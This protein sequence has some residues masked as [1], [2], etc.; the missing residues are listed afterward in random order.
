MKISRRQFAST[1]VG[2]AGLVGTSPVFS[3]N[4]GQAR[5]QSIEHQGMLIRDCTLKGETRADDVVPAHPSGLQVSRDRWLLLYA[6]RGFRGVD[7]D[8]SIVYQLRQGSPDG[9]VLCEGF[10]VRTRN[11]WDPSNKGERLVKQHGHPVAFGVSKGALIGGRVPA[12]AN[13]FVAKWRVVARIL[14]RDK[15]YLHH[16]TTDPK[17]SQRT[18]GVEWIQFRLNA[19]EDDI[20]IVQP[21]ALLRQRGYERG[22]AFCSREDAAHMN[23]SF[24]PPLPFNREATE[25]ADC[26][27][28]DGGRIAA[29][30]Y[31]YNAQ[32][33]LYEWVATGPFVED[34]K[35]TL[36]EASL[37]R[38]GE[39]W[40]IAARANGG[41][42]IAWTQTE[43][44]FR[45][46]PVP[47]YPKEPVSNSPVTA[48][49]CADGVLRLFTGSAPLSATRNGRDPLFCWDID[50]ASQF[51][52]S[53]RR[54]I[55]DSVKMGLHIRPEAVPKIDMCKLLPAQG[56][57]QYIIHR[58]SV[59]SYNHPYVGGS[60][61]PTGIPAIN[62]AEKAAC[63]IYYARIL[64]AEDMPSL[65]QFS[66][67]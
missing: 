25:W 45:K 16:G 62:A 48:F 27:H 5:L 6:T 30:R 10:L 50:P 59:R 7:D 43:D 14:D 24:T 64:Y 44:P 17:L 34:G 56:R 22:A 13:L 47:V 52:A 67:A 57:T 46:V 29:L 39:R 2:F 40:I 26:N 66:N 33:N 23:Q 49:T 8:L 31:A 11:D 65:W 35:R 41:S 12:H 20:E 32:R 9:K 53:N 42:G 58:V 61:K 37:A 4:Q 21:V 28:F 60:G 15:N 19:R 51:A 63:G 38:L 3:A 1:T 18:Q 54:V 36:S 55:F